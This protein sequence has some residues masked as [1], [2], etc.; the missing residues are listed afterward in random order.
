MMKSFRMKVVFAS[1]VPKDS[2][3][4]EANEDALELR[5]ELGRVAISDGASES[6][7]SRTWASILVSQFVKLPGV[8]AGWLEEAVELYASHFRNIEMSWSKLASFERGSFATLL[9]IEESSDG[10]SVRVT[11][12]GDSLA[13]WVDRTGLVETF[14]YFGSRDFRKRPELFCTN[15]AENGFLLF[16]ESTST[17]G[18]T[19]SL[20]PQ[21]SPRLLCM[22]D[23]LGEWCLRKAEE[24]DVPWET[25]LGM[26]ESSDLESLIVAEREAK[27]MKVDDTTLVH[28]SFSDL[29]SHELPV[30]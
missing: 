16:S 17:W 10:D 22:T 1:Q 15:P 7:D 5:P 28:L 6:F 20:P 19:W 26:R 24:G 3:F 8:D 11:G 25:L 27:T 2:S 30:P 14:P 4:P 18:R 13:V 21:D 12:V 9:G 23:A 29:E